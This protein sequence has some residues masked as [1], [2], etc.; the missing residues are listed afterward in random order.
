MKINV[1]NGWSGPVPGIARHAAFSLLPGDK[2]ARLAFSAANMETPSVERPFQV[3]GV[4]W[5]LVRRIADRD[6]LI[7][8]I[9]SKIEETDND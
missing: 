1:D 4:M 6:G 5:R 7:T 3:Q 2:E 9:C 8:Y